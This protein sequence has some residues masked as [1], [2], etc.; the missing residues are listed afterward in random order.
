MLAAPHP[1]VPGTS[2]A[3]YYRGSATGPVPEQ[4]QRVREHRP[5]DPTL[6]NKGGMMGTLENSH[7]E[8]HCSS[9]Q[10]RS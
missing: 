1:M 5:D 7:P 9:S 4:I 8:R 3:D 2:D 6:Q 10:S